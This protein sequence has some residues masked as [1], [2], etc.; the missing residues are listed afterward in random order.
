MSKTL[1]QVTLEGFVGNNP[2]YKLT[3][4][5]AEVGCFVIG[6]ED[7]LFGDIKKQWHNI[8]ILNKSAINFIKNNIKKGIRVRIIGTL[9]THKQDSYPYKYITEIIVLSEDSI[10]IIADNIDRVAMLYSE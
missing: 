5:N 9:F 1:N 3:R 8:V 2:E 10:C 6:T 7:E 4:Q